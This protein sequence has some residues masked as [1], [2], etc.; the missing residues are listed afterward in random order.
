MKPYEVT[1][2]TVE[3]DVERRDSFNEQRR[4]GGL[5]KNEDDRDFNKA[6]NKETFIS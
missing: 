4:V 6:A 5:S 1:L 2:V 3:G